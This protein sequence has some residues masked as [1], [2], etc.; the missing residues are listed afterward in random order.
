MT[1]IAAKRARF[2]RALRGVTRTESDERV[3]TWAVTMLDEET[4]ER[5]AGLIENARQVGACRA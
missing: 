2:D 4:V 3:I 1:I 5:I